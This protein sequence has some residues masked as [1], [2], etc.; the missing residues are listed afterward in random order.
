MCLL[1]LQLASLGADSCSDFSAAGDFGPI[2]YGDFE[3]STDL[4]KQRT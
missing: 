3:K 1:L 4:M 2:S